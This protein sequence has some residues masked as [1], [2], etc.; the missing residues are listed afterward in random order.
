MRPWKLEHRVGPW[1]KSAIFHG[2]TSRSIMSTGPKCGWAIRYIA[3]KLI[4]P[5]ENGYVRDGP[6]GELT[7]CLNGWDQ[8]TTL[9]S[10]GYDRVDRGIRRVARR[11]GRRW[12]GIPGITGGHPPRHP[13]RQA[14]QRPSHPGAARPFPGSQASLV[15]MPRSGSRLRLIQRHRHEI[16][17]ISRSHSPPLSIPIPSPPPH[18]PLSNELPHSKFGAVSREISSLQ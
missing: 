2:P 11:V 7:P 1:K 12:L 4:L 13:P 14:R 18:S 8:W 9:R 3:F 10:S 15:V 6:T 5:F 17:K 16:H